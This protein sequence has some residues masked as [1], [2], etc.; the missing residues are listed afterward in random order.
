MYV[1]KDFMWLLYPYCIATHLI[2][3]LSLTSFSSLQQVLTPRAL[4][5]NPLA[6]KSLSQKMLL[7]FSHSVVP[8]SFATLCT[9]VHQ[10]P[11]SM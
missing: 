7:L 9:T 8:N 11:L 6:L 1:A 10:D 4:L 5:P 3:L 2:F